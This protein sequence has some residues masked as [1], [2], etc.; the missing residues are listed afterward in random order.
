M[1]ISA[2]GPDDN[3][4]LDIGDDDYGGPL[5]DVDPALQATDKD[6]EAMSLLTRK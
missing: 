1:S 2:K 6:L 5:N 4:L 3:M